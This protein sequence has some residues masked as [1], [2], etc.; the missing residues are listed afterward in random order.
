[1]EDSVSAE[2]NT[3]VAVLRMRKRIAH[4][5]L[6]APVRDHTPEQ[7][8]IDNELRRRA[9]DGD[10][11]AFAL[12]IERHEHLIRLIAKRA[13]N[14]LPR[15]YR[16]RF[17]Y[18]DARQVVVIHALEAL[19]QRLDLPYHQV[20]FSFVD[21]EVSRAAINGGGA[22]RISHHAEQEIRKIIR[23]RTSR[24][25]RGMPAPTREN[26]GLHLG[27]PIRS[28][29]NNQPALGDS[30]SHPESSHTVSIDDLIRAMNIRDAGS[31]DTGFYGD[32]SA[33]SR[34]DRNGYGSANLESLTGSW[35]E[36]ETV[37]VDN[38]FL[39]ASLEKAMEEL[40]DQQR[41]VLRL[42]FGLDGSDPMTLEDVGQ[43]MGFTRERIRQIES[44]A[45]LKLK[46]PQRSGPLESYIER[47]STRFYRF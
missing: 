3:P 43:E 15:V 41:D 35:P 23:L 32:P 6:S 25:L 17:T 14:A 30:A 47:R 7:D 31:I 1:M 37:E 27:R 10:I 9:L 39:R 4:R 28:R 20:A 40:N 16:N 33:D 34:D 44:R 46:H 21:E 11:Q 19:P 38:R 24:E 26:L 18:E 22:I 5:N 2:P 8:A 12:F 29:V 36:D 13:H 45:L 42:R